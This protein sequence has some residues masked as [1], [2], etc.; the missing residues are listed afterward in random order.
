MRLLLLRHGATQNNIDAR[1]TGQ[2][3]IP[4]SE[5]GML[6]ARLLGDRL[7]DVRLDVIV[8]SDL[9]RAQQTAEQ[10]NR[11]HALPV[12]R[13]AELREIAMGAWEGKTYAELKESDAEYLK[14]WQDAPAEVAPPGGETLTVF[15]ARLVHALGRYFERY[16]D[17]TIAWVTHGGVIGVV[18]CH[19]LGLDLSH[20]WQFRR[21]NTAITELEIGPDYVIVQRMNDTAHLEHLSVKSGSERAQVL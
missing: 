8:T 7:K 20:R 19:V 18:L 13:D 5:Q 1:Y 11:H 21:D 10:I 6:Q 2:L 14:R 16:P 4:L 9:L 17:E 15:H 12:Y 3:D